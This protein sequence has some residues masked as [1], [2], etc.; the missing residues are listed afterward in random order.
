[1]EIKLVCYIT[2]IAA[3]ENMRLNDCTQKLKSVK[4]QNN[5][6]VLLQCP[7]DLN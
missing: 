5:P 2:Y 3:E 1:M 4:A 6:L 7:C